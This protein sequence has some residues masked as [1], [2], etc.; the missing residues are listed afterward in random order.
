MSRLAGPGGGGVLC[1]VTD[2]GDPSLTPAGREAWL[3]RTVVLLARS[4]VDLLQLRAPG[5]DAAVLL[6][7]AKAAVDASGGG[8]TRIL[9]NERLDVALAARAHGVHLRGDSLPAAEVRRL[10]P[11]PFLVGRSVHSASEAEG[12][13]LAGGLDYLI[14]GTVFP[15]ASKAPGHPTLGLDGLAAVCRRTRL[16]VLAIGGLGPETL[17]GLR[18]AGAAGIAAIGLFRPVDR[19]G[20][21]QAAENLQNVVRNVRIRFDSRDWRS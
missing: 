2:H 19:D 3:L 16:P 20:S 13:A 7:I 8:P 21:A 15:S 18:A 6:R 11:P 5:L 10:A 12:A 4:G 9:V 14:A 1:A 17:D